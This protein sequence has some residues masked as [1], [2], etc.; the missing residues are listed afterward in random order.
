MTKYSK[1]KK[2]K[3]EQAKILA[4]LL[5]PQQYDMKD[6]GLRKAVFTKANSERQVNNNIEELP[7]NPNANM[8][9]ALGRCFQCGTVFSDEDKKLNDIVHRPNA[10]VFCNDCFKF[11]TAYSNGTVSADTPLDIPFAFKDECEEEYKKLVKSQN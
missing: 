8:A 9:Y 1:S 11:F 7:N 3:I 5:G 4:Q 10:I 2:N 6:E